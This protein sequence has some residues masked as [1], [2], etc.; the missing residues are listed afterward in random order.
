MHAQVTNP[1]TD[2]AHPGGENVVDK[3]LPP[4]RRQW[5][6]ILSWFV[7]VELF[8]FA[9]LKFLPFGLAGWPSYPVKFQHWGYPSWFA[10]VI[11]GWEVF[12]AVM[13]VQPCRRFLGAAS[14]LFILTGAVATHV[15]NHDTIQDSVAA[16]VHLVFAALIALACWPADWKE[17]LR[18]GTAKPSRGT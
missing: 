18:L 12:A 15:I 5:V 3:A 13:L 9:P 2:S 1:A 10:Y 8:L 11:G 16:P 4:R 17:P 14:L 6:S 7:A